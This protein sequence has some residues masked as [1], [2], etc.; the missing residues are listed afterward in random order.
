MRCVWFCFDRQQNK[1]HAQNQNRP[2]RS[3]H[4]TAVLSVLIQRR[5]GIIHIYISTG[6]VHYHTASVR[7]CWLP[8]SCRNMFRF[9]TWKVCFTVITVT[10]SNDHGL[11]ELVEFTADTCIRN[12]MHDK[13]HHQVVGVNLLRV[14]E[15]RKKGLR[16]QNVFCGRQPNSTKENE[17]ET[18]VLMYVSNGV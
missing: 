12:R 3:N 17:K 9:Y 4:C 1:T 5:D 10:L 14:H 2:G 8:L 16:Q 18:L 13:I 11:N 7:N 6:Y 15:Q